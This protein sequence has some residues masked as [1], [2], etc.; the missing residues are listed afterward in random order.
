[1]QYK[2][3]PLEYSNKMVFERKIHSVNIKKIVIMLYT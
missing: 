3:R 2:Y 1:M